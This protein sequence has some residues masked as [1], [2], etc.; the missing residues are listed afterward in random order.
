MSTENFQL[1]ELLDMKG[2][3]QNVDEMKMEVNWP[4]KIL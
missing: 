4:F 3:S 2:S 1:F